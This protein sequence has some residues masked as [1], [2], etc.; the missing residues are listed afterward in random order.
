MDP[1]SGFRRSGGGLTD[2]FEGGFAHGALGFR[3]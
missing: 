2:G 3:V 1:D